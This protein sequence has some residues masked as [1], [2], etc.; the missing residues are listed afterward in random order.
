[1]KYLKITY[2]VTW[3]WGLEVLHC[4]KAPEF[5]PARF[6]NDLGT[7]RHPRPGNNI[8]QSRPAQ[9]LY[10]FSIT[11]VHGQQPRKFIENHESAHIGKEFKPF[12]WYA[13]AEFQVFFRLD[14]SVWNDAEVHTWSG[15][16]MRKT[17]RKLRASRK[18]FIPYVMQYNHLW[19]S[20][21]QTCGTNR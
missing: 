3:L 4:W 15:F 16:Q 21:L 7:R 2:H 14:N 10:S 6:S 18:L 19:S 1:M 5:W 12:V 17:E 9:V 11:Y 13:Q 20:F 8:T